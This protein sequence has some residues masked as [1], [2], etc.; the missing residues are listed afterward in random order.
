MKKAAGDMSADARAMTEQE[1]P[2][3]SGIERAAIVLLA[4]GDEIGAEVLQHFDPDEVTRV[5]IAMVRLR[6]LNTVTIAG[7]A[8]EFLRAVPETSDMG[9]M[10][11]T[12]KLLRKALPADRVE[13]V[14]SEINNA[15]NSNIW[16]KLTNVDRGLLIAY[17]R[18]EHPQTVAL[19]LTQLGPELVARVLRSFDRIAAR[20]VMDR[21]LRMQPVQSDTMMRVEEAL[22][23]EFLT[24][25]GDRRRLDTHAGMAEVFNHLD[26][27]TASDLMDELSRDNPESAEKVQRLMFTFEDVLKMDAASIQTLIQAADKDALSRLLRTAQES[28]K[29]VFFSN[30]SARSVSR[31][32]DDWTAMGPPARSDTEAA[33]LALLK[34]AKGLIDRGEIRSGREREDDD[35]FDA[36]S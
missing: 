7:I 32:E 23:L 28:V 5:S 27:R 29:L 24:T 10:Q 12:E 1:Q 33:Q 3:L 9:G 36:R 35:E 2:T 18:G 17:L 15:S 31:M 8:D 6:A 26:S 4:L 25:A 20:D 16:R 19:I 13:L 34:T 30:M 21:M 14:L 22:R 11:Q